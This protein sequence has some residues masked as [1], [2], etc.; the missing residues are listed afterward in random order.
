MRCGSRESGGRRCC[1]PT[2]GPT[3]QL[4][5]VVDDVDLGITHVIRGTDHLDN[6]PLHAALTARSAPSRRSTSTT[7]CSSARTGRSSRSATARRRWAT[8]ASVGSRPRRYARYLEELGLPPARRPLRRQRLRRLAV[9]ALAALSDEELAARAGAPRRVRAGPRG[10][11]RPRRGAGLADLVSSAP[12][13]EPTK[14][15]DT[16]ARFAELRVAA[17]ETLDLAGAD[18]LLGGAARGRRRPA[19]AAAGAHRRA[20]RAGAQGRHRRALARRGARP[21]RRYF[22]SSAR[23]SSPSRGT[24][25]RCRKRR[26]GRA[27]E[28]PRAE[29]AASAR[30]GDLDQ[31]Q[32]SRGDLVRDRG[33]GEERDAE[34][35]STIFFAASIASSSMTASGCTPACGRARS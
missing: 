5:S 15:P 3:Y 6:A 18:E 24:P 25:P 27:G 30:V 22:V 10:A 19:G 16:L 21:R 28:S 1:A 23:P 2:A 17:P 29:A 33:L 32:P 7:A 26:R 9:D 12:A 4:A 31:P 8:C 14:S 35:G 11:P 13:P 20:A 34:A